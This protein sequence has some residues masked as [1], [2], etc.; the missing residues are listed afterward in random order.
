MKTRRPSFKFQT[1]DAVKLY[2]ETHQLTQT[3]FW[4]PVGVT[5][6]GGSRYER[7]RSIPFQVQVLLHMAYGT[8]KQATDMLT[9]LRR[10]AQTTP[11]EA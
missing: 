2:R 5:Q 9:W 3:E 1:A 11:G 10:G 4:G 7:E 8:E 6:S